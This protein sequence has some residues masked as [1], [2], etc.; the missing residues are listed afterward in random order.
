[1]ENPRGR[2]EKLS[3]GEC[4][5]PTVD[6]LSSFFSALWQLLSLDASKAKGWQIDGTEHQ[7]T[8]PETVCVWDMTQKQEYL[9]RP[10]LSSLYRSWLQ[11]QQKSHSSVK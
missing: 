1:M 2:V 10:N 7:D 4:E 8:G 9:A 6:K 3:E 5:H 11:A